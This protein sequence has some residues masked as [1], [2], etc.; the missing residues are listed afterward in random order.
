VDL[1]KLRVLGRDFQQQVGC[2]CTH[3]I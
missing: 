1:L 3:S 2:G